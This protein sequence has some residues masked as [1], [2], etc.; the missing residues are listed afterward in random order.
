MEL[1][2]LI[3]NKIYISLVKIPRGCDA[4]HTTGYRNHRMLFTEMVL[5]GQICGHPRRVPG[6]YCSRCLNL[7]WGNQREEQNSEFR[8]TPCLSLSVLDKPVH[9]TLK[10]WAQTWLN[11]TEQTEHRNMVSAPWA[12]YIPEQWFS[13]RWQCLDAF[14]AVPIQGG[15]A[16]GIW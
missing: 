14:L 4:T 2:A 13:I 9:F 15:G 10:C 8:A 5:S 3:R 1:D 7:A 6:L 12:Y 11:Q 16:T